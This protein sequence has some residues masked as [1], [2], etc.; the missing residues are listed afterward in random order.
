MLPSTSFPSSICTPDKAHFP[1][2][3]QLPAE[4]VIWWYFP[5]HNWH[6]GRVCIILA[7]W[8]RGITETLPEEERGE[9]SHREPR[10][11]EKVS[12]LKEVGFG[13]LRVV[14]VGRKVGYI[15]SWNLP[16]KT[17]LLKVKFKP[18]MLYKPK[19]VQCC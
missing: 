4:P 16:M 9:G 5:H 7:R 15:C 17:R 13:N 19:L 3:D 1:V 12:Y 18:H 10:K 11:E 6:Y 2:P 8:L 14:A